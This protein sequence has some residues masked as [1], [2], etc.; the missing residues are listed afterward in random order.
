M[1]NVSNFMTNG[2]N[3]SINQNAGIGTDCIF[4]LT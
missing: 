4:D 1:T 2:Y 3:I